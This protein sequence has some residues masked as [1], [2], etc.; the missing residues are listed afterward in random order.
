MSDS[1]V[2]SST[3][4]QFTS[5]Y[6]TIT[7]STIALQ[8]KL[9]LLTKFKGHIKKEFINID[10]IPNY[11]DALLIIPQK[12]NDSVDLLLLGHSSLCYLIKRI[13]VQS[14]ESLSQTLIKKIILKLIELQ[15]LTNKK[16]EITSHTNKKFWLLTIKILESIYLISPLHLEATLKFALEE[17]IKNK[18]LNII[19]LI[20]LIINELCQ[21]KKTNNNDPM[22]LLKIFTPSLTKLLNNIEPNYTDLNTIIELLCDI[23][24]KYMDQK[25][26]DEFIGTITSQQ[27]K[28]IFSREYQ[29]VHDVDENIFDIDTELQLILNNS[30]P[31][32]QLL[33]K[34][35]DT[36]YNPSLTYSNINQLSIDLTNLLTPFQTQKETEKNWK[37]RQTNIIKIR[38]IFAL[39]KNLIVQEKFEFITILKNIN[40]F[41][42]ISKAVLSLRTT[43]SL[44]ACQLMKDL[45]EL[46]KDDLTLTLL[47]HIF[48]VLKTLL[49]STKKLSSQMG[50]YCLLIM[51]I[52]ID[53]HNRLFQS[54]FVLINE[55]NIVLRNSSS[56]L[57]R[58]LLIKFSS[59]TKLQNNLI[60][61]EEW[62]KKGITD[63]QTQVRESMRVTFWYYYKCYPINAKNILNNSFSNQLKKAIEL[64]IPSRLGINYEKQY[65]QMF[66][67]STSKSSS[68]RSSLLNPHFQNNTLLGKY[69]SYAQP[70]QSSISQKNKA[71]SIQ[72]NRSAS[73][74]LSRNNSST[75]SEND[76][77]K[78]L[79]TN[80]STIFKRKT[81]APVTSKLSTQENNLSQFDITDEL[82]DASSISM[83]NKY[84]DHQVSEIPSTTNKLVSN[85][86]VIDS[87]DEN[88][89]HLEDI[90]SS[91]TRE[92]E[93]EKSLQLVQNY[94]LIPITEN[95]PQIDFERILPMMRK[96]ITKYPL[97]FKS[98]LSMTQFVL[99]LPV[100][101]IIELYSINNLSLEDLVSKLDLNSSDK[102]NNFI[103]ENLKLL[104]DLTSS[105]NPTMTIFYMKYRTRIFN[106]TME[107]IIRLFSNHV[108]CELISES[109]FKNILIDL[110][111]IDGN[112][113]DNKLYFDLLFCCYD[114]N[115]NV[116]IEKLKQLSFISIKLKIAHELQLRDS[117]FELNDVILSNRDKNNNDNLAVTTTKTA[118]S[119]VEME[120]KNNEKDSESSENNEDETDVKRYMEMTMINPFKQIRSTSGNSVIH[121]PDAL[122]EPTDNLDVVKKETDVTTADPRLYEMTKIV[123]IYQ[124]MED[125]G[126]QEEVKSKSLTQEDSSGPD[127]DI[128]LSDIFSNSMVR[129][130]PTIK[131]ENEMNKMISTNIKAINK[132]DEHTVKFT[133]NSPEII[134]DENMKE[135]Q[136]FKK[137]FEQN[138]QPKGI[139]SPTKTNTDEIKRENSSEAPFMKEDVKF[140]PILNE[141]EKYP[142]TLY[143]LAK[144]ISRRKFLQFND[145]ESQYDNDYKHLVKGVDR[146]ESGT[147]TIKHLNYLMEPL[148]MFDKKNIQLSSWLENK[149]GYDK[150][151]K[152]CM[153][154]LQSTDDATLIP[155]T[156]TRKAILLIQS[157]LIVNKFNYKSVDNLVM[158]TLTGVWDQFLIM[159][160]RLSDFTN[161]IYL[162]ICET[163]STLIKLNFFKPKFITRMLST[164][165]TE[166]PEDEED[167]AYKN[168][169]NETKIIGNLITENNISYTN[170]DK[171]R[172]KIGLKQSFMISTIVG[173]LQS[174][175]DMFKVFQLSEIIQTMS[176]F[177]RKT[178]ADW[179]YNSISVTVEIYRILKQRKDST[180]QDIEQIFMCLD[181]E[182]Y[183]LIRIMGY[184]D[185]KTLI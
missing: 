136:K 23:F 60:Y 38:T 177:V 75:I 120:S 3:D 155:T 118:N 133:E 43:L 61:I 69:P 1:N 150:L 15:D 86:S 44:N 160:D 34:N 47:D 50:Y 110:F 13:A 40:F 103:R 68:R 17:Q 112:E 156:M 109:S 32:K 53:F 161:E 7:D 180:D 139:L 172:R 91:F 101:D 30:K 33:S 71:G 78:R 22:M 95:V 179:R 122:N 11:I 88:A 24:K 165:V 127:A 169:F 84:M 72:T 28:E 55:K 144:V 174:N 140:Y 119:V 27:T 63:A 67:N 102:I 81:S 108:T 184:N 130:E 171:L 36:T 142:I 182:T 173:V 2:A 146:I 157:I 25:K 148:I 35:L 5:L 153:R 85:N 48:N 66:S 162:L 93:H 131:L 64:S 87:I 97:E 73:E 4:V 12:F 39:N 151:L 65:P 137:P 132:S 16:I 10:N 176:F 74:I 20:L 52:N 107:L 96:I 100:I 149:D 21:I 123:S 98:L 185:D 105:H 125:N 99:A 106:F 121:N 145:I 178:N 57:L 94:L 143:E 19:K 42:S 181:P 163:R 56:I 104:S 41:D 51:L 116:F 126:H 166:L 82:P 141:F 79:K 83:I 90:Y 62:L 89:D 37:I 59:T 80:D 114:Y 159:V 77:H 124:N 45:L 183:K 29:R 49:S 128:N 117:S 111:K 147:F 14:P 58:I 135:D 168:E 8:K 26:Y 115:K 9:D 92:A 152:L 54:C 158:T 46:F 129:K 76:N 134:N 167:D 138:V 31:P 170:I 164:L 175:P 154:L 113:F 6:S 18:N 70:T